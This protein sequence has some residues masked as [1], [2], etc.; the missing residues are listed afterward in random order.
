MRASIKKKGLQELDTTQGSNPND[1]ALL[2][3]NQHWKPRAAALNCCCGLTWRIL[4]LL[5]PLSPSLVYQ[6]RILCSQLGSFEADWSN[7]L[8]SKVFKVLAC[9]VWL[10]VRFWG[11]TIGLLY[12]IRVLYMSKLPGNNTYMYKYTRAQHIISILLGLAATTAKGNQHF[13]KERVYR[14]LF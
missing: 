10:H 1:G 2:M 11:L 12:F 8:A 14:Y 4:P 7:P 13:E 5:P 3:I 9:V 6:F